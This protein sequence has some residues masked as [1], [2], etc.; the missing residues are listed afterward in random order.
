[1]LNSQLNPIRSA[2]K[3]SV[4]RGVDRLFSIDSLRPSDLCGWSISPI[5]YFVDH[6][7]EWRLPHSFSNQKPQLRSELFPRVFC[8]ELFFLRKN[9]FKIRMIN[10]CLVEVSWTNRDELLH[11]LLNDHHFA[12]LESASILRNFFSSHQCDNYIGNEN[13]KRIQRPIW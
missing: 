7:N 8:L 5:N 1:M 4:R 9:T 6:S 12:Q 10:F 2:F 3:T 13:K 11:E